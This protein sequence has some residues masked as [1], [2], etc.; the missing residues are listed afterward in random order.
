MLNNIIFELK[1]SLET[2][3][4]ILFGYLKKQKGGNCD[5]NTYLTSNSELIT[6]IEDLHH[7]LFAKDKEFSLIQQEQCN[8]IVLLKDQINDLILKINILEDKIQEKDNI[9]TSIQKENQLLSNK[10]LKKIKKEHFIF[11]NPSKE[12]IE[13]NNE[14]S[15]SKEILKKL[16]KIIKAQSKTITN[17]DCQIKVKPIFKL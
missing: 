15:F 16:S 8:S 7:K 6:K 17:Q 14:L 1:G 5:E 9:I 4:D 2:N 10:N 12:I 3:K 11:V 13:F